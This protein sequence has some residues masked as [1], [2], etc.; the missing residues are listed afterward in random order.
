M[1][2]DI[3]VR[4]HKE[5][6]TSPRPC[7]IQLAAANTTF[8]CL[9]TVLWDIPAGEVKTFVD[10]ANSFH[11]TIKFT[12][13]LSSSKAVFLDTEVFKGPRFSTLNIL[14]IRTHFKPTETFQYTHF[15][16][17]H[18]L[19]TK[20]GFI[21][22]E[23]LRLL[24]TNSVKEN[25]E[26]FKRDFEDSTIEAIQSRSLKTFS[27]KFDLKTEKRLYGLNLNKE[28]RFYRLSQLTIQ[29]YRIL[30]RFS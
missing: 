16:T 3:H 7:Q 9:R 28:M 25:F 14:D 12:Y 19:N 24:R 15:S 21:K 10:F 20:K 5:N 23:T 4:Q 26:N 13:E 29:L 27:V 30:K 1:Q 8:G 6:Q 17:C 18:P 11:P 2:I 22:G